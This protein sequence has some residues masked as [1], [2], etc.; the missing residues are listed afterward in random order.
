MV[1]WLVIVDT[2]RFCSSAP[3]AAVPMT[4][5]TCRTVL[6][7]PEAAPAIRGS[8]LRMA[9]VTI[10]AKMQPMPAPATISG[11]RKTYHA[12]VVVATAAAQPMPTA[13][14][15]RPLIRMYLPPILSVSRPATGARN[16][17][18]SEA[19]ARVSPARSAVKPSTDCR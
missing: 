17:D 4:R 16:I 5:P 12:D 2:R 18:I 9:T 10:G 15:V 14:S 6:S 7:T 19:G 1:A 3:T 11:A 8:M 13:N